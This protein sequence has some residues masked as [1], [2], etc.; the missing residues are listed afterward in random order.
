[1]YFE[2]LAAGGVLCVHT[3]NRHLDLVPVVADIAASIKMQQYDPKTM[4][5]LVD[6]NGEPVMD[7]LV[8][9]RPR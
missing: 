2:K 8:C 6:A 9:K 7:S 4:K 5:P 3:S 1:M